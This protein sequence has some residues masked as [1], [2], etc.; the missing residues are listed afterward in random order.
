MYRGL[1][2]SVVNPHLLRDHLLACFI[3]DFC[4]YQQ[5]VAS[6]GRAKLYLSKDTCLINFILAGDV[7][8]MC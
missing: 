3:H 8:G 4:F 5:F 7:Y 2:V 6:G 1:D